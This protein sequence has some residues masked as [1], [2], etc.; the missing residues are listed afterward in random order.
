MYLYNK[1]FTTLLLPVLLVSSK[2]TAQVLRGGS[3]RNVLPPITSSSSS[4]SSTT[5]RDLFQGIG[6]CSE[7]IAEGEIRNWKNKAQCIDPHGI[8]GKG[9]V[10]TYLCDGYAD[11]SFRFCEDGTIR[12]N[13]SGFCLVTS[14]YN[15]LGN[16]QMG[17]CEVYPKTKE[18]QQWDMV[19]ISGS[20]SESGVSQELFYIK[21]RKSKL[22]LDIS[23]NGGSGAVQMYKCDG[24]LDQKY[25]IRSRGKVVGRGK[26]QNQ[27]SGQCL[28]VAGLS[29]YG[30]IGTWHCQDEEDQ[31]FTLYENG[32][33][34]NQDSNQCVDIAN[35]H[36]YGNV[37]TFPCQAMA[38][39][40]WKQVLWDESYFSLASKKSNQCLDVA[41][42]HGKGGVGTYKCQDLED[43]R[44]K[45][46]SEK[47]TTP[48][49]S[50]EPVFCNM[51][52]SILQK[53]SSSV[54]SKTTLTSTTAIEIGTEIESGV[55]FSKAK[56]SAKVSQ[57]IAKSWTSQRSSSTDVTVTCDVNDDESTFTGGCLWQWHLTTK[58]STNNVSW[59]AGIAKCTKSA[60]EPKCPPFTKCADA[61]CTLCEEE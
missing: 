3:S 53:I 27:K 47:W 54:S 45:W 7:P 58:S 33:L 57:S 37:A 59:R 2:V 43:Q 22:C 30:N 35:Y 40:Q 50:W 49:G 39:Q 17:S 25:Y 29:G 1:N 34:V 46:I 60:E 42:Y 23:G 9:N 4:S 14:G 31:V 21:N 19:S 16:V 44:W 8:D 32:E 5:T 24:F 11:Q 6:S 10:S 56:V 18:E 15:G 38:D 28:D 12:S 51:N 48:E 41:G 26:L 55:I 13:Q 52:G 20:Y 61:K 36:G